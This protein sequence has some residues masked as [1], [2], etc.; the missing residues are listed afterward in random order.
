VKTVLL[1][2][3]L[4]V[5]LLVACE[6]HRLG[7]PIWQPISSPFDTFRKEV[8]SFG[9]GSKAYFGLGFGSNNTIG[10][11]TFYKDFWE[12]DTSTKVWR[13][14]A[15]FPGSNR[16]GATSFAINGKG[17][18]GFGYSLICPPVEGLCSF[19]T[20]RDIWEYNPGN[21]SWKKVVDA[22]EPAFIDTRYGKA[23]SLN[24]EI[25]IEINGTF[26]A[27][28]PVT[29]SLTKRASNPLS[30]T[31]NGLFAIRNKAY[32]LI[33]LVNLNGGE[34]CAVSEYDPQTDT[35]IRKKDFP[36]LSRRLFTAFSLNGYG[37][38]GGGGRFDNKGTYSIYTYLKDFWKYDPTNDQW[39][40]IEDYPGK[41]SQFVSSVALADKALL[42]FG[43][44]LE[45]SRVRIFQD[46]WL[47]QPK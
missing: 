37:Y 9:I 36:G 13:K 32:S 47:F 40:R 45:E 24:G 42:G 1:Q 15:D 6:D 2:C 25:Y 38:C 46:F 44:G 14:L 26:F 21:D 28:N 16:A 3:I 10:A 4:C 35:W 27:F 8:P 12:Y 23:V 7:E 18:I 41:G 19:V 43:E 30:I 33:S 39:T 29:Y 11:N 17:Y 31:S 5:A 20:Y 22:D 34:F